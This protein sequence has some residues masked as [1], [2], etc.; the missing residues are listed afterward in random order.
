MPSDAALDWS[1]AAIG[2]GFEALYY[3]RLVLLAPRAPLRRHHHAGSP[4]RGQRV[5]GRLTSGW[6]RLLAS[7][8]FA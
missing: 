6:R 3:W 1:V 5:S 4:K 8:C 2:I 7:A